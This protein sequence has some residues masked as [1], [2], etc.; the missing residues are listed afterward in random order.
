MSDDRGILVGGSEQLLAA[1][2]DKFDLPPNIGGTQWAAP[3]DIDTLETF[4]FAGGHWSYSVQ[5][6]CYPPLPSVDLA[7]LYSYLPPNTGFFPVVVWENERDRSFVPGRYKEQEFGPI[8]VGITQWLTPDG[9]GTL[10]TAYPCIVDAA[11]VHQWLFYPPPVEIVLKWRGCYAP[12]DTISY[13]AA[14]RW[15]EPS[16]RDFLETYDITLG[17]QDF[18]WVEGVDLFASGDMCVLRELYSPWWQIHAPPSSIDLTYQGCYVPQRET[19]DRG[20]IDLSRGLDYTRETIVGN[21]ASLETGD[22]LASVTQFTEVEELDSQAASCLCVTA[23]FVSYWFIYP[24]P[25]PI[26]L[27]WRCAYRRPRLYDQWGPVIISALYRTDL[28]APAQGASIPGFDQIQWDPPENLKVERLPFPQEAVV[29]GVEPGLFGL[30]G[31]DF[32]ER[33]FTPWDTDTLLSGTPGLISINQSVRIGGQDFFELGAFSLAQ[34]ARYVDVAGIDSLARD[35]LWPQLSLVDQVIKIEETDQL[36]TYEIAVVVPVVADVEFAEQL[37]L[38]DDWFVAYRHRLLDLGETWQGQYGQLTLG[39]DAFL[40]P[41]WASTLQTDLPRVIRWQDVLFGYDPPLTQ[42]GPILADGGR[43]I[44]FA[45]ADTLEPELPRIKNE[46]QEVSVTT[47][48]FS[49]EP[50]TPILYTDRF[51]SF[52]S[53]V[54]VPPET[55]YGLPDMRNRDRWPEVATLDSLEA[56]IYFVVSRQL[57]FDVPFTEQGEISRQWLSHFERAVELTEAAQTQFGLASLHNDATTLGPTDLSQTELGLITVWLGERPVGVWPQQTLEETGLPAIGW[58]RSIEVPRSWAQHLAEYG[59]PAATHGEQAVAVAELDSL[60]MGYNSQVDERFTLIKPPSIVDATQYANP[61]LANVDAFPSI[62]AADTF[63][64][65]PADV[66]LWDR[67]VVPQDYSHTSTGAVAMVWAREETLRLKERTIPETE[68]GWFRVDNEWTPP[69]DPTR[70]IFVPRDERFDTEDLSLDPET[71]YGPVGIV[72]NQVWV[73]GEDFFAKGEIVVDGNIIDVYE[74]VRETKYN[75]PDV[76]YF[77]RTIR[78]T[79]LDDKEL[80]DLVGEPTVSPFYIFQKDGLPLTNAVHDGVDTETDRK[81]DPSPPL[82]RNQ[83]HVVQ[84]ASN[85]NNIPCMPCYGGF[86]VERVGGLYVD[87]DLTTQTR[88]G[89]ELEIWPHNKRIWVPDYLAFLTETDHALA[90]DGEPVPTEREIKVSGVSGFVA[91]GPLVEH[92]HRVIS[93]A[94]LSHTVFGNNTPMVHFEREVEPQDTGTLQLYPHVVSPDPQEPLLDTETDSLETECWGS[95]CLS[96]VQKPLY[97]GPVGGDTLATGIIN[98]GR[99]VPP[100]IP[101]GRQWDCPPNAST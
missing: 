56:D 70:Y 28:L 12:P 93:P 60:M 73:D 64:F 72:E 1:P 66:S 24:P 6:E 80:E 5:F 46:D 40:Y 37:E 50:G 34:W 31:I 68:Y 27:I 82:V 10:E 95:G 20:S 96:V 94:A 8:Q 92:F 19:W 47:Q 76:S 42:F 33:A 44:D 4:A 81:Y 39:T 100:S 29:E 7:W 16:G 13:G 35:G 83:F 65:D 101:D 77:H 63:A 75:A 90:L 43:F 55:Q 25:P 38:S 87:V 30:I 86:A 71:E 59:L 84:M 36:E 23:P 41:L 62:A 49:L 45:P 52:R 61:A 2:A 78:I 58:E 51:I 91:S 22:I 32:Y 17:R 79:E 11:D 97:L 54:S 89:G 99:P 57:A 15:L 26:E 88:Y 53:D 3:Q 21:K 98:V 85:T 69:E 48:G 18:V 67:L 9:V 14:E 74:G